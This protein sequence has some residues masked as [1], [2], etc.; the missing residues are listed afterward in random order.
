MRNEQRSFA[1]NRLFYDL[2]GGKERGLIQPFKRLVEQVKVGRAARPRAMATLLAMPPESSSGYARR[3]FPRPSRVSQC[4]AASSSENRD[5]LLGGE[6]GQ[7]AIFLENIADCIAFFRATM[8][9]SGSNRPAAR[10]NTV[11]LPRP[12]E[13]MRQSCW[14]SSKASEKFSSTGEGAKGFRD[15]GKCYHGRLRF[16]KDQTKSFSSSMESRMI[17]A[18]QA[19]RSGVSSRF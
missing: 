16:L 6:P 9:L 7:Q 12:E 18:V 11:L 14:P 5:V 15:M 10:F 19:K 1:G 3:K 2:I 4:P 17:S 13:P 8:P